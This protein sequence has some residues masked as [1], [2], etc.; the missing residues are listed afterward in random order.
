MLLNRLIPYFLFGALFSIVYVF[1]M[2]RHREKMY[3][4]EN[5]LDRDEYGPELFGSIFQTLKAGMLMVG[6]SLG[7]I[8]GHLLEE[9]RIL[10]S[11]I[12]YA[13]MALL[14]GGLSLILHYFIERGSFDR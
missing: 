5:Q 7:L 14:M 10:N 11:D 12:G 3:I 8:I 2:V 6:I 13:S 1:I 4:M 9:Y